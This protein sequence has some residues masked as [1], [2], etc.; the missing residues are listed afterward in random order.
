MLDKIFDGLK[1]SLIGDKPFLRKLRILRYVTCII[2]LFIAFCDS[3]W[4]LLAYIDL[5]CAPLLGNE[6]RSVLQS[7]GIVVFI[8]WLLYGALFHNL[9]RVVNKKYWMNLSYTDILLDFIFTVYF[10]VYALNIWIEYANGFQVQIRT[11]TVLAITYLVFC[12]LDKSYTL[13]KNKYEL[14]RQVDYTE[15]C[16]S[17]GNTIPIDA[18]VFYK[19]K[20][21]E[22]VKYNGIYR[23]LPYGDKM[24]SSALIKLEDAASDIEGKLLLQK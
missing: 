1:E 22:V 8:I 13:H 12:A 18:K 19:G 21:Y 11:E 4:N 15:Y 20:K 24:I 7:T 2:I 16:D 23:L 6:F 3:Y 5:P 14:N 17:E 10:L 9:Y